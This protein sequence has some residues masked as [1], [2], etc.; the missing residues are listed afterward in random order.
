[1]GP[2]V[3]YTNRLILRVENESKAKEVL[4]L[5][6]RN[7]IAF[8]RYEPTRPQNFY[9]I[10]YHYNALHREYMAYSLGTFIRYYIYM[11]SNPHQIIGSI[12]L[13]LFQGQFG[14]YA[15]IG[16]KIDT[17]FQERGIAY[18][19]CLAAL[20]VLANDYNIHQVDARIHPNNIA[21]L[22]LATKLGFKPLR[23]EPQSA[24]I[25]GQYVD[26]MRYSMLI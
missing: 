23:L 17:T 3:K 15:E 11:A 12:N 5:Y 22:R 2:L 8:E 9:T 14:P 10:D 26:L 6:L 7:Q 16:Y 18:E 13:N 21:S 4:E 20:E 19:A 25:M 24:N 1:M